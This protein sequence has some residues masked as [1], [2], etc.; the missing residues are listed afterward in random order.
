MKAIILA[1]GKGERLR[2]LTQKIP[3]P[4][5]KVSGKPLLQHTIELLKS[6]G[7][8]EFI[9]ALC[10]KPEVIT[11][12]F[13]DGKK[14]GVEIEYTY[15]EQDNPQGT[16]GAIVKARPDI[17]ST[18]IVTS[19]DILRRLDIIEMLKQHKKNNA[20]S[21]INIYQRS[22]VDV[23]S[24]VDFDKDNLLLGF[25]ERPTIDSTISPYVWSNG[26]F[27]I[28]EKD[29]FDFIPQN[30]PSDFGRDIFPK[31]IS[32]GKKVYGYKTSGY[33]IDVADIK[34]LKNARSTFKLSGEWEKKPLHARP[35][36]E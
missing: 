35:E 23:K 9:I 32:A 18:F 12:Y 31:I 17:D 13:G 33:F 22:S 25:I 3:K 30:I 19:G 10:Y 36:L 24:I 14:F 7:I 6:Y 8:N 16:A 26:S 28:F 15:E 34:R 29:I 11:N 27:Y 5:V 1:G 2:P 20:F 4:M 21:T